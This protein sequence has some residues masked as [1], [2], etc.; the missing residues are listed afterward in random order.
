[1]WVYDN[2]SRN[3]F[4]KRKDYVEQVMCEFGAVILNIDLPYEQETTSCAESGQETCYSQRPVYKFNNEY[5]RVDEVLFI[6]KPF[7]VIEFGT[8]DDLIRNT[9]EDANPFPYDLSDNEIKNEV[10]YSLGI[11]PYPS[12]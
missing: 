5:F 8:Y 6:E 12:I 2:V 11:E 7:I 4:E 10:K 1:M 3:E 9:M